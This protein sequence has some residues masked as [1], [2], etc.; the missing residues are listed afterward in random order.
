MFHDY[1]YKMFSQAGLSRKRGC[2]RI[3]IWMQDAA[4]YYQPWTCSLSWSNE[5]S[6]LLSIHLS[7]SRPTPPKEIS[8]DRI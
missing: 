8:C 5:D 6:N 4:M 3:C 7:P 2:F 1:I